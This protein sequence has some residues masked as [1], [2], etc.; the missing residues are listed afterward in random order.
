MIQHNGRKSATLRAVDSKTET[1]NL[2]QI[3]K[4]ASLKVSC[5]YKIMSKQ[6]GFSLLELV[7]VMTVTIIIT[8]VAVVA[9]S[10][11]RKHSADD[12]ARLVVDILD[13]ARQK[14]LN[15]RTTFRV[16]INKTRNRVRLIDE[17]TATTV[18]DDV[19]IKSVPLSSQINIGPIAPNVTTAPTAT[20]PIPVATYSSS[21][22]P[23][24]SGDQKITLRFRRNGQVVDVGTDNLGTGSVVN[25]MTIYVYPKTASGINPDVVRA[26]TVLGTS[27]DTSLL[28]CKFDANNRCT[29]WAK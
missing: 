19:E 7:I 20:S 1:N 17:K 14:A 21:T 27:G 11:S 24:S 13:E 26:V 23:L 3:E 5:N 25:G 4:K 10:S 6:S 15:Q 9:Y 12:Q 2:P 29:A 8:T 22:Y 18:T 28:K 16:E